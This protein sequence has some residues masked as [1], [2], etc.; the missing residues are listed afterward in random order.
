MQKFFREKR[1]TVCRKNVKLIRLVRQASGHSVFTT[2]LPQL[3]PQPR[4]KREM[5]SG[6]VRIGALEN[7]SEIDRLV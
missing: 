4:W 3:V 1:L 7:T 2:T 5:D 6:Q